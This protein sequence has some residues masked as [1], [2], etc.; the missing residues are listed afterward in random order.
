VEG[1][2]LSL[3]RLTVLKN[4]KLVDISVGGVEQGYDV[5]VV[6]LRR[7]GQQDMHPASERTL[8]EGDTLAVLG[9]P[10][11]I[12]VVVHDSQ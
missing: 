1:E 9:S 11:R 2:A 10:E 3:A 7:N 5:S 8:A 6:L 4:S 12:S